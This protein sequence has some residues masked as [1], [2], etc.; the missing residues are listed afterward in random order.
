MESYS[1]LS[2]HSDA[3]VENSLSHL[4]RDIF[5]IA[6]ETEEPISE[7]E[8]MES[9]PFQVLQQRHTDMPTDS[10]NPD[11]SSHPV[12]MVSQTQPEVEDF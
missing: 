4:D 11:P 12:P 2:E 7:E 6:E 8:Y 10:P 5:S 1:F 3:P 9:E